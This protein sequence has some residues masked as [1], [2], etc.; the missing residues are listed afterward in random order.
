MHRRPS[1]SR[2]LRV[3]AALAVMVT[4]GACSGSDVDKAGG[5]QTP[6]PVLLTLAHHEQN[7]EEIQYWIDEVQRRSGGSLRIQMT[8]RYPPQE[9]A[10]DKATIA[11]VQA[12]EASWPRSPPAPTTPS[13]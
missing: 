6:Q 1:L 5:T 2:A 10:Y 13:A 9:F 4:A 7:P 8:S 12:G 11:D 3:L